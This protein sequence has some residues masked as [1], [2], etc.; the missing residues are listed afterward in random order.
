[1]AA[2]YAS[3]SFCSMSEAELRHWVE[4]NPGRVNDKDSRGGSPLNA[5]VT[6][7]ESVPLVLWLVTEKGADVN[8]TDW[9]GYG[10][11]HL[12]KSLDVLDALLDC[13]ADPIQ[14]DSDG[15]TPLMVQMINESQNYNLVGRLLQDPRVQASVNVQDSAGNTALHYAC[16][17]V[18]EPEV[19]DIIQ[20]LLRAGADLTLRNSG[21]IKP[22]R[23]LKN[24]YPLEPTTLTLIQQDSDAEKASFLIKARRLV[25]AATRTAAPSYLRGRVVCGQPLPSVALAPVAD[26]E[27]NEELCTMLAFLVGMEGGGMPRD[28]FRVVL[29]LVMPFWDPLRR[30]APSGGGAVTT[31]GDAAVASTGSSAG[32]RGGDRGRG[33]RVME[34]QLMGK[35]RVEGGKEEMEGKWN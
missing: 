1:M 23:T 25:M 17:R 5:A 8:G 28:V 34:R 24:C 35:R 15:S 7:L 9:F 26:G 32:G 3:L 31:A 20:L 29:D 16:S 18:G 10:P 30:K 12:A 2:N 4:A 6:N 11:L 27:N 14:L 33:R 22:L 19:P 21:G 13:A